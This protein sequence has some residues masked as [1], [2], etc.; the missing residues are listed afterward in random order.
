MRDRCT[1]P[2]VPKA[3]RPAAPGATTA[4]SPKQQLAPALLAAGP[5]PMWVLDPEGTVLAV[6]DAALDYFGC[7]REQFLALPPALDV[8]SGMS[9]DGGPLLHTR[10]DGTRIAWRL[11]T[12]E[13]GF[14]DRPAVLAAALDATP[15]WQARI[16][17]ARG[18]TL[19]DAAAEWS[20][21][22]NAERRFTELSLEFHAATGLDG[23]ALLGRLLDSCLAAGPEAEPWQAFQAALGTRK[24]FR[25]VVC[26][27]AGTASSGLWLELSGV[28]ITDEAGDFAGYRGTGRNV[29]GEIEAELASRRHEQRYARFLEGAPVWFWENDEQY[30]LTYVSRNSERALGVTP[31]DYLGQR[32]TDVA[33]I[34]IEP[35]Q[36]IRVLAAQSAR[37]PYEDF[38]YARTRADGGVIWI[39]TS[40]TPRFDETGK[41]RGYCGLARDVTRQVEAERALR[42]RDRSFRQLFN[43]ASDWLWE[44]AADATITYVSPNFETLYSLSVTEILGRRLLDHPGAQVEP[45]TRVEIAAGI[46]ARVP[47]VGIHYSR[48]LSDGRVIRLKAHAV[49]TY[50][51][52]GKYRGYLGV[53]KDVT[54]EFEAER[55]LRD[56]ERQFRELLEASADFYW[57]QDTRYRYTYLSP[58]Y[59]TLLGPGIDLIGRRLSDI[60]G[61]SIDPDIGLVVV[62][63]HKAKQPFRD[64]VFALNM[65]DG[66]KH[67][68]KESGAPIFDRNGAFVG[69]RGVGAAITQ[70]VEAE[71]AARLAQQRLKEAVAY[72]SQPIV[73][74]DAEDRVVGYNQAFTDLHKAPNTNTPVYRDVSFRELALWQLRYDFYADGPDDPKVDLDLLSERHL[75][76]AEHTYHLRDGRW[77]LV[78]YRRLPGDSRVGLWT[79]VTALKQAEAERRALERQV[80]HSQRLEALGTLAGGVAHEMNNALVP[81]IALTKMVARKLPE[82]SRE[83]HNLGIV[84]QAA[85]RSRDLLRQILAF[86]RKETEHQRHDS[87]DVGAVLTETL[88]LMRAMLPASVRV[89]A[90]IAAGAPTVVGDP[91]QLQQVIVNLMTNAAQAIGRAQGRVTARLAAAA[92]GGRL[93]L[94]VA[95]TGCGM[96]EETQTR[97]FE[98]FF[99]TKPVGE[100][101]GLGLSVVHGIVKNHGGSIEV[102]STP[103]QGTRFDVF[104]PA[105]APERATPPHAIP[106]LY[107]GTGSDE[108]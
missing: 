9:E 87:V 80:H 2:P 70:Q 101:S 107:A 40:G 42:E 13:I 7:R 58:S 103:G 74:Y 59:A 11:K 86:S 53:S 75:T 36:G 8:D 98:P 91:S 26:R 81:V 30:R 20:W 4:T 54:E 34:M 18:R 24:R 95:D 90:E 61:V 52:A 99:T 32:L 57:E 79:D 38:I 33:G 94:S 60:K 77:M 85:E 12:S 72:V 43:T 1:R 68:F 45:E 71:A 100:G 16:A 67:W 97:I 73:V 15:E 50:D 22:W 92:D 47:L 89:E 62:R 104:L 5:V 31:A 44:T 96:D 3:V 46:A 88:Q 29:T 51:T 17:L 37:L 106:A 76:E 63:A 82:G 39:N 14:A 27:V 25:G 23:Q 41:F 49:P 28:P 10:P 35:E 78:V 65:P 83:Q 108:G 66:K 93:C 64:F 55:R 19:V 69:Y 84:Q 102:A 21:G 56:S 105:E 6:N 48:Q